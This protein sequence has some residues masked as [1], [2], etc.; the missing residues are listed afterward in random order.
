M[1]YLWGNI[2]ENYLRFFSIVQENIGKIRRIS[3]AS[4]STSITF[5]EDKNFNIDCGF[6][7]NITINF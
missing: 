2:L 7:L 4:V 1:I 5:Y 6:Y 3:I